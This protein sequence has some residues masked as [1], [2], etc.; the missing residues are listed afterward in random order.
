M[1]TKYI[2]KNA[3]K[4]IHKYEEFRELCGVIANEAQ[5]YIDWDEN[6][7]CE[8]IPSDGLC[9]CIESPN[10]HL[11]YNIPVSIFFEMVKDKNI[12]TTEDCNSF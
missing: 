8:Y 12:L 2:L 1:K 4:A 9:I 7:S 3:D 5:K 10:N 11:P 6:V